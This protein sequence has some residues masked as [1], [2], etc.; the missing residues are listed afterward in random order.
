MA[1]CEGADA[2]SVITTYFATPDQGELVDY[3]TDVAASTSLP[4]IIYNHP[5]RTMVNVSGETIRKLCEIGNIVGV[6]DSSANMNNSMSYLANMRPGFSVLSG[7]DSLI[8]S[9]MDLGGAGAV[10]GSANFVPGLATGICRAYAAGDRE[11]AIELQMRLFE[12]RG[13]FT[14]GTYP[15]MIKDACKM[16]G[17]DMGVCRKPLKPLSPEDRIKLEKALRAAGQLQ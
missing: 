10:S 17:I 4:I 14:L 9:L 8:V 15:A 2:V 7:N 12:I 16:M 5:L 11:K 3:Y 13:V 6:K 1:E